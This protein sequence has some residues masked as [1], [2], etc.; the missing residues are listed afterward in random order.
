MLADAAQKLKLL[1]L[2][3]S[4]IQMLLEKGGA[5]FH[6][7]I[8]AP[9]TGTVVARHAYEGQYVKAGDS[10]FEIADFQKCGSC[11]TLTNATSRGSNPARLWM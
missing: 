11:S 1:G 7:E 3:D 4:Q 10:L 6:T 2:M 5:D 8:L 9:M